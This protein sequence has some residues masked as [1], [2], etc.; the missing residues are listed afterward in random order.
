MKTLDALRRRFKEGLLC[1]R[2]FAGR[3]AG[4]LSGA[5]LRGTDLFFTKYPDDR[6]KERRRD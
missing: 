4:E 2:L 6:K 1:P 5:G 3:N